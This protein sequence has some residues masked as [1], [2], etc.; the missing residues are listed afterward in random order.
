M[1]KLLNRCL[2]SVNVALGCSPSACSESV[3]VRPTLAIS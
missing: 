2:I 3:L 1:D